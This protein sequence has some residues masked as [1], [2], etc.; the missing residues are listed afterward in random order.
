MSGPGIVTTHPI[1][2]DCYQEVECRVLV[3]SD[4]KTHILDGIDEH[5]RSCAARSHEPERV[6]ALMRGVLRTA[7]EYELEHYVHI[8]GILH[9]SV[10][11]AQRAFDESPTYP[12]QNGV[13]SPLHVV[14]HGDEFTC[15]GMSG[16][17]DET[18]Q[19]GDFRWMPAASGNEGA[20]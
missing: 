17:A 7:R 16:V 4:A 5:R 11:D 2:P 8:P 13:Y 9:L 12:D 15:F 14:R 19:D 3:T 10:I 6:E 18:L 20:P 1:C